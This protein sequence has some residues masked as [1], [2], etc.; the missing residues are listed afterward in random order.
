VDLEARLESLRSELQNKWNELSEL[1][2]KKQVLM[3]EILILQGKISM[4]QE[5]LQDGKPE[6]VILEEG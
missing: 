6:K 3:N 1:E 4:L 2:S 5:L